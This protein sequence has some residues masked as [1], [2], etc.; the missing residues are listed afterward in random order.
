MD[1]RPKLAR[2]FAAAIYE[3]LADG[4]A[5]EMEPE[6]AIAKWAA[7][8][9]ERFVSHSLPVE[10]VETEDEALVAMFLDKYPQVRP[11]VEH[12]KAVAVEL[13][14]EPRF[15]CAVHSDPEGC[16]V[17]S[18]GQLVVLEV[19]YEGTRDGQGKIHWDAFREVE[20]SFHERTLFDHESP[21]GQLSIEERN[22]VSISLNPWPL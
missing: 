5:D 6:E 21:Y 8:I 11:V 14:H 15:R 7:L 12:A 22:L 10:R 2:E 4:P 13:L 9:E 18:E 20:E 16:H 17:C 1:L 19:H 3:S